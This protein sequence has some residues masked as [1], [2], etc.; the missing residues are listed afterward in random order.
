MRAPRVGAEGVGS[1]S[2]VRQPWEMWLQ[3][4][5]RQITAPACCV[6]QSG[7]VAEAAGVAL[8]LLPLWRPRILLF[9]YSS[10]YKMT[11]AL[12]CTV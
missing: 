3:E 11:E 12:Y 1:S 8:V 6:C 9:D 4:G 10:N 5:L 7:R 2:A